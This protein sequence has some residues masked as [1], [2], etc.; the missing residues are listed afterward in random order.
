M[1]KADQFVPLFDEGHES[2]ESVAPPQA[3]FPEAPVKIIAQRDDTSEAQYHA[4]DFFI[5]AAT[6]ALQ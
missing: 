1:P 5:A 4:R 6:P 2:A 3:R